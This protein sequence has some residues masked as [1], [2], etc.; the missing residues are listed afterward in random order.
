[1]GA[2]TITILGNGGC[3]NTGLPYNAFV[4]N[5]TLLVEAPPDIMLSLQ[6]VGVALDEID[7]IFISH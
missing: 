5:D 1:M 7:T 3:L 6:T 4:F 2:I